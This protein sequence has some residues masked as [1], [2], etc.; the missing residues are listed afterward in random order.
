MKQATNTVE[1]FPEP[2]PMINRQTF[3][4]EIREYLENAIQ[5]GVLKPGD[6]ILETYWAKQFG[7]SQA[8]VRE[9][10][11]DLEAIGLVE[12]KP[13]C[14]STV[15]SLTEKDIK[16]SFS[17][18][19]CLEEMAVRNLMV[20]LSEAS[21]E[22]LRAEA[23]AMMDAAAENDLK[24]FVTHDELFHELIVK[25]S[26]NDVLLRL[27]RQCSIRDWT[28]MTVLAADMSIEAMA[29][30][31]VSVFEAITSGDVEKAVLSI[32]DHLDTFAEVLVKARRAE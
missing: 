32:R 14:G 10:I 20:N 13:Y 1:N 16:D 21:T 9:A 28:N 11:R 22:I 24:S 26:H 5:T 18:R 29:E 23:Q 25:L 30:M 7:V 3:R 15:R 2:S 4:Q 27:W 12:T 17:V 19:A 8:P 6:R 31:H